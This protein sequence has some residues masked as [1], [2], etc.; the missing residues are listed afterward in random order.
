MNLQ[1]YPLQ[2]EIKLLNKTVEILQERVRTT[3][4]K[5]MRYEAGMKDDVLAGGDNNCNKNKRDRQI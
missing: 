2:E 5:L 3:E 1:V 4:E